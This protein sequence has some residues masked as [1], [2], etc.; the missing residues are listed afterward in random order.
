MNGRLTSETGSVRLRAVVLT[1][2]AAAVAVTAFGAVGYAS[3]GGTA[4]QQ[5]YAP[6]N[7]AAPTIAG[8]TQVGSTLTA[9][10]GTFTGDQPITYRYQWQRCDANGANCVDTTGANAQSYV[11]QAADAGRT[12]RVLVTATNARGSTSAIS[13][14]TAVVTTAGPAGQIRLP[15]GGVSIPATSVALPA[16]L[17][18]DRVQ[19]TPNPVRSR[20]QT[21]SARVRVRDT[22]GYFI[23]GAL[24]FLRSVPLL[25]TTPPEQAT[26]TNGTVTLR[27]QPRASFPLRN[28]YFVQFFVRARKSGDNP[29]AGVSTRRLVQ[30]RTASR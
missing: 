1:I 28:G 4:A 19:F 3:P 29:L 9:S 17:L 5:Q 13:V 11:V 18:I 15:G 10:N 22:R 20:A 25:T 7:T 16:R 6:A 2:A 26:Q 12:L 24:V 14:P 27:L 8:T 21:I 23:R 30:L